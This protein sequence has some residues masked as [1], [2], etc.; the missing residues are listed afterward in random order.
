METINNFTNE[1]LTTPLLLG[2]VFLITGAIVYCFPPKKINYW[3]GYRTPSSMQ[4]EERWKF[5]QT[6]SAIKMI[7]AGIFLVL[8]SALNL[9]FKM[10]NSTQST[11][12][13]LLIIAVLL[14]LF[15]LTEN[16]I[17][18]KFPKSE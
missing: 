13:L 5:A 9:I 14:L 7:Q 15:V 17:K 4:S 8:S 12:S 6:F 1:L 2:I 10:S 3:Y 16:A 11:L 18:S